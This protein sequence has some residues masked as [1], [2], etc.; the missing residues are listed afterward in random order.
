MNHEESVV[1]AR[2]VSGANTYIIATYG[3][4][5]RV[6]IWSDDFDFVPVFVGTKAECEAYVCYASAAKGGIK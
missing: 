4:K 6:H 1:T 3:E 2:Y 5:Y